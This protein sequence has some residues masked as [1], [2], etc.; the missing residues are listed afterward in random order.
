MADGYVRCGD[1]YLTQTAAERVAQLVK[2]RGFRA[3][4]EGQLLLISAP[5][6]M[7]N[8]VG[9]ARPMACSTST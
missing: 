9:D 7:F 6:G 1:A 5:P 4:F 2:E 8:I 3:W